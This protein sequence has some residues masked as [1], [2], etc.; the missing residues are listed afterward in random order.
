MRRE[1]WIRN[2]EL[3]A[4]RKY[5]SPIISELQFEM[6]T[7]IQG[8]SKIISSLSWLR[9]SENPPVDQKGWVRK[10]DFLAWFNGEN[11]KD[12]HEHFVSDFICRFKDC[13]ENLTYKDVWAAL[14]SHAV[15]LSERKNRSVIVVC[16]NNVFSTIKNMLMA[17][18]PGAVP[19]IRKLLVNLKYF[20]FSAKDLTQI[21][22]EYHD[23]TTD[24]FELRRIEKILKEFHK[25]V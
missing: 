16:K 10:I 21:G 12:E 8:K 20:I 7:C 4:F 23:I 14:S 17:S 9:S 11:F 22:E 5:S 15:F 2:M 13:S 25:K 19:I 24:Y 1:Y 6:G 3:I 18:V